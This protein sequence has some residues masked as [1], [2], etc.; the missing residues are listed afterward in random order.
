[1]HG[2][3]ILL[4]AHSGRTGSTATRDKTFIVLDVRLLNGCRHRRCRQMTWRQIHVNPLGQTLQLQLHLLHSLPTIDNKWRLNCC[5]NG[6][7]V[8]SMAA[9]SLYYFSAT[10]G[11]D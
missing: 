9:V 2:G 10:A 1:V 4:T 7:T 5:I 6:S 8:V 3:S 11:N